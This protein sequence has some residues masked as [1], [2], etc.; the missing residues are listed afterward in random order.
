VS[1]A[2]VSAEPAQGQTEHG[3]RLRPWPL[4]VALSFAVLI[5]GTAAFALYW[6]L[7]GETKTTSYTVQGTPLGV[8]IRVVS[9]DVTIVGGAQGGIS[10]RRTDQSTFGHGPI[11][12]Q[13]RIGQRLEIASTCPMMVIGACR[14]SYRIAVPDNVPVSIRADHGSITVEG[15]RGS[16]SLTTGPGAISVTT[17]CGYSLSANTT[18]GDIAVSTSCSPARLELTSTSGDISASVPVDR[19]RIDALAGGRHATVQGL[20]PDPNA[21]WQ[22]RAL[23]EA[24]HVIVQGRS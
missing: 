5:G 21:P 2:S 24:G 7:S 3:L 4:L 12:W 1:S 6:L 10:V 14:A 19:Y 9:G 20:T 18:G 17:F 22:I 16:A 8:Q 11:E 23:S 15:Y 13:R